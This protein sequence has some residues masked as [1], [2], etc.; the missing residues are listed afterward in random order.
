META[1]AA[2]APPFSA[3]EDRMGGGEIKAWER[4]KSRE[5]RT[6][7]MCADGEVTE[8][9]WSAGRDESGGKGKICFSDVGSRTRE[10]R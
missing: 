10:V 3:E 5:D 8:R 1:A 2:A 6:G 9:R 7:E 4:K